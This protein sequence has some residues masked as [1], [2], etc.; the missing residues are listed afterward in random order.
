MNV[1]NLLSNPKTTKKERINIVI[2]SAIF[3]ACGIYMLTLGRTAV[4]AFMIIFAV[5]ISAAN[6]WPRNK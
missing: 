2:S 6:L 1:L 3:L 4:G 5:L